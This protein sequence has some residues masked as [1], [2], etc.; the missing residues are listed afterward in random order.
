M[1]DA[2]REIVFTTEDKD[3]RMCWAQLGVC[4]M[5]R[6]VDMLR[7]SG[8]WAVHYVDVI[9]LLRHYRMNFKNSLPRFWWDGDGM[10]NYENM[11]IAYA[12]LREISTHLKVEP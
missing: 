10:L 9:G 4:F 12:T 2:S 5:H 3:P 6:W 1:R 7:T 11:L 8:R